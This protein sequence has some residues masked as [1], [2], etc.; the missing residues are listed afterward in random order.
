[1]FSI[2]HAEDV[3]RLSDEVYV[4]NHDGLGQTPNN[5]SIL[6]FGVVAILPIET[7][8]HIVLPS[9]DK[10]E[11]ASS[12]AELMREGYGVGNPMLYLEVDLPTLYDDPENA[13]LARITGHEGRARAVALEMF[14][15]KEIPVHIMLPGHRARQVTDIHEFKDYLNSGIKDENGKLRTRV[16]P[17]LL[18]G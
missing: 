10:H 7:F 4:D 13:K 18:K 15:I 2:Q 5:A 16:F 6:Y 14:G 8:L 17:K 1:M 12:I 3:Y 11:R 9:D